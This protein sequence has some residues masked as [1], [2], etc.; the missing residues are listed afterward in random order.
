M[1]CMG[2]G[3]NNLTYSGCLQ[4]EGCFSPKFVFFVV[5][6]GHYGKAAVGSARD[7]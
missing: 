7:S 4:C 6:S 3:R 1:F 2:L 5:D